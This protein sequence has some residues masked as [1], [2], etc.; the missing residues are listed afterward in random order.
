MLTKYCQ[1]FF[2][3]FYINVV[4]RFYVCIRMKTDAPIARTCFSRTQNFVHR[5]FTLLLN[6][7]LF[8]TKSF[9]AFAPVKLI[10]KLCIHLMKC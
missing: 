1:R 2:D 3:Q 4:V 10:T 8:D 9:L 6:N 7:R 5:N